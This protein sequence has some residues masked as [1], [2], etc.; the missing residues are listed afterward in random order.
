[1]T[2][3]DWCFVIPFVV[4]RHASLGEYSMLDL[5]AGWPGAQS[6]FCAVPLFC[7]CQ[8]RASLIIHSPCCY[9]NFV[10]KPAIYDDLL[11]MNLTEGTKDVFEDSWNLFSSHERQQPTKSIETFCI[12]YWDDTNG[13][14]MLHSITDRESHLKSRLSPFRLLGS[15]ISHLSRR[16]LSLNASGANAANKR[17]DE[18]QQDEES[19]KVVIMVRKLIAGDIRGGRERGVTARGLEI[20]YGLKVR[21]NGRNFRTCFFDDLPKSPANGRPMDMVDNVQQRFVHS[22]PDIRVQ[23]ARETQTLVKHVGHPG[24]SETLIA[25]MLQLDM[26]PPHATPS[27]VER[28]CFCLSERRD[29][30]GTVVWDSEPVWMRGVPFILNR[31]PGAWAEPIRSANKGCKVVLNNSLNSLG[32]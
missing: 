6:C 28:F 25:Q 7:V 30:W 2:S 24:G 22:P 4:F 17:K 3:S 1:M 19:S 23:F 12:L 27:H 26:G 21:L 29:E 15:R 20:P 16:D 18:N 10:W 32:F 14:V 13:C 31:R 11:L 9:I 8:S 5:S